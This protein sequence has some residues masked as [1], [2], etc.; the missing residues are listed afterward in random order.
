[1]ISAT[2]LHHIQHQHTPRSPT[3]STKMRISARSLRSLRSGNSPL[4]TNLLTPRWPDARID[5]VGK[6]SGY[7]SLWGK[8]EG[9]RL[10]LALA[11]EEG[12]VGGWV[13]ALWCCEG[14]GEGWQKEEE[15]GSL[16]VHFG[17]RRRGERVW[18]M[19]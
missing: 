5:A 4:P 17:W 6:L 18:L 12:L 1:M 2:Y 16:V 14:E 15:E 19:L 3:V 8:V 13:E 10:A 7:A 9:E 11:W